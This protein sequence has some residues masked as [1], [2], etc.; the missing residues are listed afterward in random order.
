MPSLA[1]AF[2][3][4]EGSGISSVVI[5][6]GALNWTVACA[7]MLLLGRSIGVLHPLAF[8]V[9]FA[10]AKEVLLSP[11]LLVAPLFGE[12]QLFAVTK[13]AT[14][15]ALGDVS[16]DDVMRARAAYEAIELAAMVAYYSGYAVTSVVRF[17][18]SAPRWQPSIAALKI[19]SLLWV[20]ISAAALVAF[21]DL[22][23]GIEAHLVQLTTLRFEQFE[24]LGHLLLLIKIASIAALALAS[25]GLSMRSPVIVV[26]YFYALVATYLADGA[27]SGPVYFLLLLL[28]IGAMIRRRL[29]TFRLALASCFVLAALGALGLLRHDW[30]AD[31][32]RWEVFRPAQHAAWLEKALS[33]VARRRSEEPDVAVLARIDESGLL[34]GKTYLGAIFFFV[35]RSIWP[36]KPRTA[37]AYNNHFNFSRSYIV[38]NFPRSWGIPIA[39]STEAYWNFGCIG[40]LVLYFI[41]GAV[42]RVL[43]ALAYARSGRGYAAALFAI[44]LLYLDGTGDGLT[45]FAQ[46]ATALALIAV[47]ARVVHAMLF[48]GRRVTIEEPGLR[49]PA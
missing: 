49:A 9:L 6:L 46:H 30:N 8:P 33:E 38:S 4:G 41:I 36:E 42:L 39:G 47:T 14:S 5:F 10:T 26:T 15:P 27:R 20:A 28:V 48:T 19:T 7:P 12:L 3:Y 1:E 16:F 2:G 21:L 18:F 13:A 40:V 44:G 31:R 35:P 17:R 29:P 22:R 45:R 34:D 43:A 32:V 24:T 23:G 25:H 37:G 11:L